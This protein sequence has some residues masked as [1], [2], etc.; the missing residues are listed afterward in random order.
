VTFPSWTLHAIGIVAFC[1]LGGF[2]LCGGELAEQTN[3]PVVYITRLL[4][5]TA[6]AGLPGW[7]DFLLFLACT[8]PLALVLWVFIAPL[9]N[10]A[11]TGAVAGIGIII[12]A[13]LVGANFLFG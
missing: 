5:G 4:T 9:F 10:N 11:I 13:L 2:F 6:C 8:V 3:N 1:T 12:T 7:F